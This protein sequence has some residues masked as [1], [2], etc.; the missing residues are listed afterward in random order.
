VE[1]VYCEE[2]CDNIGKDPD[3]EGTCCICNGLDYTLMCEVCYSRFM[4][5]LY[6]SAKLHHKYE[7]IE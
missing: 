4:G 7:S 5:G 3:E 6:E 1:C 2:G